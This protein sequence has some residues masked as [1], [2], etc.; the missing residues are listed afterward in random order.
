[1]QPWAP[2]LEQSRP[3]L[4]DL[5]IYPGGDSALDLIEDDGISCGYCDG[6][7][8]S[9]TLAFCLIERDT[10]R[11]SIGRRTGTFPGMPAA[12]ALR[13]LFHGHEKPAVSARGGSEVAL[14]RAD[15]CWSFVISSASHAAADLIYDCRF[16]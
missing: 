16:S 6:Q 2:C 3:E 11:L 12:A 7:L 14:T 15:D 10:Y 1:M 8:V 13:V 5:H 4:L 9:T